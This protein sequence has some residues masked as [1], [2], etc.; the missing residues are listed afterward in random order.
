MPLQVVSI[1]PSEPL[2]V[3]D[4]E[5]VDVAVEGIGDAAYMPPDAKGDWKLSEMPAVSLTC[6]RPGRR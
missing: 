5:L 6:A 4:A 3:R 1:Q 2:D